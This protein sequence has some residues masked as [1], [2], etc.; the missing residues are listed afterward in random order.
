MLVCTRIV[1]HPIIDGLYARDGTRAGLRRRAWAGDMIATDRCDAREHHLDAAGRCELAHRR[2][3]AFDL[4]IAHR[5]GVAGDIVG[6]R[7]N[8][9]DLRLQR[10]TLAIRAPERTG[11]AS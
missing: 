2:Q 8:H 6:A 1:A 11:T 10:W 3:I 7:E 4:F 9:D 5:A